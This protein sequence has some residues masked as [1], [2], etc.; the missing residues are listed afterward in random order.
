MCAWPQAAHNT[1]ERLVRFTMSPSSARRQR[2]ICPSCTHTMH[3]MHMNLSDQCAT[4]RDDALQMTCSNNLQQTR[5][6]GGTQL[7]ACFTTQLH[8]N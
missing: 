5:G 2:Q 1:G 7:Q 4:R 8:P 3:R 6:F